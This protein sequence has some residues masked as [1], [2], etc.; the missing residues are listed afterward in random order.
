M[1]P[2]VF[3]ALD[4]PV[5]ILKVTDDPSTDPDALTPLAVRIIEMF[6][7]RFLKA[8]SRSPL[9]KFAW[10][11]VSMLHKINNLGIGPLNASLSHYDPDEWAYDNI[12]AAWFGI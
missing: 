5:I 6:I 8:N 2:V 1:Y 10:P 9:F 11:I 3:G 4:I 7:D 12:M